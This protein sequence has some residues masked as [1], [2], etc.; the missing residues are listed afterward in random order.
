MLDWPPA[1]RE[2]G[3][4]LSRREI[5]LFDPIDGVTL[6]QLSMLVRDGRSVWTLGKSSCLDLSLSMDMAHD[7]L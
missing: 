1:D 3:L 5:G 6:W 7:W 2:L 4:G